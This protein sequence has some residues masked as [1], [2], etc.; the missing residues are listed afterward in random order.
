MLI[1]LYSV[2]RSVAPYCVP[3]GVRVVSRSSITPP[4]DTNSEAATVPTNLSFVCCVDAIRQEEQKYRIGRRR[5]TP[6]PT[7]LAFE[8]RS[9]E[10]GYANRRCT[11]LNGATF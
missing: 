11:G 9:R 4:Y 3:G 8:S 1:F 2:L 5:R 7:P 6:E 10:G